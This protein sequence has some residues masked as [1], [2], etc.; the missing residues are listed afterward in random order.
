MESRAALHNAPGFKQ[1]TGLYVT[2]LY[3]T[4]GLPI[5]GLL[6]QFLLPACPAG[7]VVSSF[8]TCLKK[9]GLSPSFVV[10]HGLGVEAK[11]EQK[12]DGLWGRQ[13]WVQISALPSILGQV[14]YP[15]Y[16][17]FRFI[18]GKLGLILPRVTLE[19]K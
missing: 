12:E 5:S 15:L 2:H 1:S 14:T 13:A 4:T 6:L 7:P 18:P 17:R 11:E 16:V 8:L 9:A 19:I 3:L 10:G